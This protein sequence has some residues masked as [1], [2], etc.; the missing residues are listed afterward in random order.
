MAIQTP[1]HHKPHHGRISNWYK[2]ECE[3]G[4]GF[5]IMGAFLDHRELTGRYTNTSYVLIMDGPLAHG[6]YEIVTR[7]SRYELVGPETTKA[8][9][10]HDTLRAANVARQK[11]WD[12]K[13]RIGLAFRAIELGG[14]AGEALN[15]IKKLLRE[16]EGIPGSRAT[17]EDLAKELADLVICADLVAMEEGIDLGVAVVT[18]FNETSEKVGLHTRLA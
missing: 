12:P 3:G 9:T 1:P 2:V 15:V 13:G 4:L 14:E 16:R 11:E 18:K 6:G 10:T 17:K 5:Y 8:T 7:N